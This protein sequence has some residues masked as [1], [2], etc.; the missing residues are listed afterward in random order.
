LL[1]R[2][3]RAKCELAT[4]TDAHIWLPQYAGK[5]RTITISREFCRAAI[6]PYVRDAVELLARTISRSGLSVDAIDEV[7]VIG[8]SSR[9][10]LLRQMLEEDP[11]FAGISFFPDKP[12]WDVARGAAVVDRHPGSYSLAETL[13]LELSDGSYFELI[14][15]GDVPEAPASSINLALVEDVR[16]ANIVIDR[17]SPDSE[18]HRELAAQFTVPALGF[19]QEAID[20]SWCITKD[21]TLSVHGRSRASGNSSRIEREIT[22]LRFGY[23]IGASTEE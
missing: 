14:R 18:I 15:P 7:V 23:R 20:L 22:R 2:C 1:V 17:W 6:E 5:S 11:R 21:L 8:G 13:G 10:W 12:E 19:D 4:A 3:E 16:A 9:L